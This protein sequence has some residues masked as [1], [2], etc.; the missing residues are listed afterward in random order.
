MRVFISYSHSPADAEFAR[1]LYRELSRRE[2]PVDPWIDSRGLAI[3]TVWSESVPVVLETSDMVFFVRSR[4]AVRSRAC[5]TELG[6]AL[7]NGIPVVNLR[8]DVDVESF[9]R[10]GD[11]TGIDFSRGRDTGLRELR[12]A[13]ARLGTVDGRLQMTQFRLRYHEDHARDPDRPEYERHRRAAEK[14]RQDIAE[15]SEQIKGGTVRQ[16]PVESPAGSDGQTTP[17]GREREANALRELLADVEPGVI[18]VSGPEGVG[19]TTVVR[20]ELDRWLTELGR[21]GGGAVVHYYNARRGSILG[22]TILTGTQ[23]EPFA[24]AGATSANLRQLIDGAIERTRGARAVIVIDSA[25]NLQDSD[26]HRMVDLDL[27]EVFDRLYARRK[28]HR[29]KVVLISRNTLRGTP[30]YSW[31]LLARHVRIDEGLAPAD[32][33]TLLRRLDHGADLVSS[34][35]SDRVLS[36]AHRLTRG[37]PRLAELILVFGPRECTSLKDVVDNLKRVSVAR[38]PA[39]VFDR[40]VRSLHPTARQVLEAVAAYGIPVD[41]S[42][43]RAVLPGEY[44]R[45]RVETILQWLVKRNIVDTAAGL[46]YLHAPEDAMVLDAMTTAARK[47]LLLAAAAVMRARRK[48]HPARV[49]DLDPQFAEINILLAAGEVGKAYGKMDRLDE[50]LDEMDRPELLLSQRMRVRDHLTDEFDELGNYNGLGRI[51]LR[52]GR[53]QDARMAFERAKAMAGAQDQQM[54]L[55]LTLHNLGETA[56]EFNE[57][58]KAIEYYRAALDEAGKMG[59]IT[60]QAL[61]LE[62]LADSHRRW[63]EYDAAFECLELAKQADGDDGGARVRLHLVGARWLLELER[64]AEADGLIEAQAGGAGR[65]RA[66]YLEA[67]ADL[68]IARGRWAE[69]AEVAAKAANVAHANDDWVVFHQARTSLAYAH[70]LGGRVAKAAAAIVPAARERPP[71]RSLVVLAIRA[72][73]RVGRDS[74]AA[75]GDFAQ[76]RDEAQIRTARDDRDFAAY[77]FMGF[78]ICGL[79]VCQGEPLGPA[80]DAFRTAT[81]LRRPD[82]LGSRLHALLEILEREGNVTGLAEAFEAVRWADQTRPNS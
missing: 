59:L 42:T 61:P 68:L 80:I 3:G 13:L 6:Y 40:L 23:R 11:F 37:L 36:N 45:R 53:Y 12:E 27:E 10:I 15:L 1:W 24:R 66:A 60:E 28:Q 35:T 19:K 22:V 5:Q 70:L 48:A 17:I 18:I 30:G 9:D 57:T 43:I 54:A 32:F 14:L 74:A 50:T 65:S 39:L 81:D 7:E 67:R 26:S 56:W 69:G 71:G 75:R 16:A 49:E 82:G 79:H 52:K 21:R 78:G 29:I 72:L 8:I 4:F 55:M 46:F 77:D 41:E 47:R 44:G 58:A 25:E 51:F 62:G 63:G 34:T 33:A 64:F 31:H 38:V 73:T 2:F 76:L 20:A